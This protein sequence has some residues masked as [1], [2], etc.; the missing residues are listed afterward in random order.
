MKTI[1]FY[2][3]NWIWLTYLIVQILLAIVGI[4]ISLAWYIIIIPTWIVIIAIILFF[5]IFCNNMNHP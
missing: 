1:Q 4:T 5:V 3:E 2:K